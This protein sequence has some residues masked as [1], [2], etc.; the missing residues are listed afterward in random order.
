MVHTKDLPIS[1]SHVQQKLSNI[2]S[3]VFDMGAAGVVYIRNFVVHFF[4][5]PREQIEFSVVR[6][7]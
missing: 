3:T 2:Y 1:F 6:F 5:V 4:L 7:N